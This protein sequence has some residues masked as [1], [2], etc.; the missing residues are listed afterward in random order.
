[1]NLVITYTLLGGLAFTA[2]ATVF[3]LLGIGPFSDRRQKIKLFCLLLLELV[4]ITLAWANGSLCSRAN[5]MNSIE[6]ALHTAQFLLLSVGSVWA[7]YRFMWEGSHRR[8]IEFRIECTFLGPQA[9]Y[10]LAEFRLIAANRGLV[11]HE[12]PSIQLKVRGIKRANTIEL[13]KGNE[14]RAEF[15]DKLIQAEVIPKGFGYLFVE[16]NVEQVITYTARI[17]DDYRFIMAHAEFHYDSDTPHSTERVFEVLGQIG[18]NDYA[19]RPTAPL[20]AGE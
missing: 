11:K 15:P 13:W 18:H 17:P 9:G 14:P 1:M 12:F 3:S 6:P 8:R 2:I 20:R 10:Y 4:L 5:I 16:P 19:P 7:Y